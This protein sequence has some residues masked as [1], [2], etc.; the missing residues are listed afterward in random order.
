MMRAFIDGSTCTLLDG[1]IGEQTLEIRL[2][3]PDALVRRLEHANGDINA[4]KLPLDQLGILHTPIGVKLLNTRHQ[5]I[6]YSE[7]HLA[8]MIQCS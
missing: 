6:I 1:G 5:H 2:N 3:R 8:M 4:A 7:R